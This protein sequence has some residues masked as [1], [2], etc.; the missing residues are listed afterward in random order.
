MTRA[1][2]LDPSLYAGLRWRNIGPFR[3]GRALAAAGVPGEP[4]TFYFGAVG[5]G[6]WKTT[7]SG[8]VW[9][10]IFDA[11]PIASIG[12]LAVA[13]SNPSVIYVGTGEADMR[14]D[15]SFGDGVYKSTDAGKSWRNVGL[16]ETRHI[17]RILIDAHDPNIVLV[18]ALGRAYGPN[19]ERGVFRSTDGGQTWQKVL[20][21]DE[22]TGAIDL[23]FDPDNS[24]TVFAS[25]WRTR[26]PPWSTYAPLGGPGSGLYKSTDEGATWT[27][28]SGHGLPS[29]EVGRIG[30]AVSAGTHGQRIYAV[31]DARR[32]GGLYRSD[33]GGAD[34]TLVSTDRR[35]HQRG[36]YF[37]TVTA[38]P[39][40]PNR[41]Y[42][43]NVSLYRSTD[44][45][46]TFTSI[47]GA[48]GGDDYH[49][50][51]VDPGDSR[52][53]IVASDQGTTIS[54]DYGE[55]WSSWYNQPTA[56]FYHV[57]TDNQFPYKVY[58]AQQDSGTVGTLSRSDYGQITF[59]DWRPVGGDEGGY[60]VPDPSD[61]N[62]V[63]AGGT[64]GE[65]RRFNWHTGESQD[66]SP[67]PSVSFGTEISGRKYRFT[68]TSPIVFSPQDP[69]TLYMGAQVLLQT[70]DR[71]MSWQPIS[72][73]LTGAEAG[74]AGSHE[75]LAVSNAMQRGYG[76]I[77]TIAPSAISPGQIW[78]G[79]DTGL[80]QL[81]RDGGKTWENVTPKGLAPWS[82][83]SLMDASRFD[84]GTAYAAVDRH[85]VDDF[86]PYIYRTHD[87]GKTWTQITEGIPDTAYVHAV[88]E[89][90]ELKGLLFAGSE[91][92]VYVSFDDGG[93]WQ[94]LQLNLPIAPV[95]DLVI[96]GD[97][98]VV[99]THGRSFWILDDI[100]PLRHLDA[101]VAN[102]DVQ[103][104]RPAVALRVRGNQN[105]DTPLPPETPAG[106][107]PP[108]G[109]IFDYYL[110]TAPA[111]P[112]VLEIAD[113]QGN[114]VRR[115]SSS[116]VPAPVDFSQ[117]AF[118]SYWVEVPHTLG[119]SAGENR[120]VWDLRYPTP[121]WLFHEYSMAAVVRETPVQP[122]GPLVLPGNYEVRLTVN[123]ETYRQ[124]LEIKE[125]P[126]VSTSLADLARQLQLELHITD[127]VA[128]DMSAYNDI[129]AV[130]K[131]VAALQK[132]APKGPR[133][134]KLTAAATA[135]DGKLAALAGMSRIPG[136]PAT[137][138]N[139]NG[140]LATLL[141]S[142]ESGDAAPT[143][144]AAEVFDETERSLQTLLASWEKIRQEDVPGLNSLA[145]RS[146]VMEIKLPPAK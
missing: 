117:L 91:T 85:R 28:I 2:G 40:D 36:W 89:D 57:A 121:Q 116:D 76:V 104:F 47:K 80:I 14:S 12:A 11:A 41:V 110:K 73:D 144:Q 33:D 142:V 77:Y 124:P 35:I 23:T 7:D 93:H 127:T 30:V 9:K 72:P 140:T 141:N 111:G 98:L 52:R 48:P 75:P 102:S 119:K 109:A 43:P 71:G 118:P 66:I 32:N 25:L 82:K 68:W 105:R 59:R 107:N 95:H 129:S 44:G 136:G 100:T 19:P 16:R 31:V 70:R 13:P 112:V 4:E 50:L 78:V 86:R 81:T 29:S 38:D 114:V 15:I 64:L 79:T 135:L 34:W 37:G 133:S 120:F 46:K 58:G 122:S 94:S 20:Y 113:A 67:W 88:R 139:L 146:R 61:P 74:A 143:A 130:R 49:L 83:I 131:Q 137:L 138:A 123:G 1:Q 24:Q 3:G 90:P 17:G 56:Q 69:H 96:H 126:R 45:G 101:A 6:V 22:N 128:K 103:L 63:F 8:R 97:D 108:E 145:R 21:K 54:L 42:I 134:A 55:T 60:M 99:A 92:G 53:M 125:D 65:L 27:E 62:F 18:A 10:P 39:L 115:F 106:Q 26:R 132:E 51:W 84:A 87:Y 5:G